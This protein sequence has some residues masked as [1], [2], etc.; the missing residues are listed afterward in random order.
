MT[1]T[2]TAL[3]NLLRAS[4]SGVRFEPEAGTDWSS[5]YG[6]SKLHAVAALAY[7]SL[8]SAVPAS[9]FDA[10]K[11]AYY[12]Q[13]GGYVRYL[14]SQDELCGLLSS[15]DIP[16]AVLKGSAAAMYYPEPSLRTMGDIDVIVRPQDL[17]RTAAMMENAGYNRLKGNTDDEEQRRHISFSKDGVVIEVHYRFS[18]VGLDIDGIIAEGLDHIEY[19]NLDGHV[20][21]SLPRLANGIVLLAHM[22]EHL[23]CGLGLRQMIDW[24]MYVSRELDDG[25][26]YASFHPAAEALKLDKLASVSARLSQL[27]L[28]LSDSVTWCSCTDE[29]LCARLMES[30]LSSGNFGAKDSSGNLVGGVMT[31][32]RKEGLF[33]YLQRIGERDWSFYHRHRWVRPLAF[34]Y[35]SGVFMK[36]ALTLKRG[37]DRLLPHMSS[38]REKYELLEQLGLI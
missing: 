38:S 27:Y 25:S 18:Y 16:A 10:W 4:L 11:T 12:S 6:S 37:G 20:F 33:P 29:T 9:V 13:L 24:M 23:R 22:R 2:D 19:R 3:L 5:V 15:G 35:E 8:P 17:N 1:Q 31:N 30:L 34:F 26:W 32:I 36:K 7:G 14:S 21:P 28:G